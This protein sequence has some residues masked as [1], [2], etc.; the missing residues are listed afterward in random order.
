MGVF[1]RN[2]VNFQ[3]DMENITWITCKI[4]RK[5]EC[6]WWNK[7][8]PGRAHK[9]PDLYCTAQF[10][11]FGGSE[12]KTSTAVIPT[13]SKDGGADMG[14]P[15]EKMVLST[16]PPRTIP[17]RLEEKMAALE[18]SLEL[19]TSAADRKKVSP[20]ISFSPV[21]E[22]SAEEKESEFLEIQTKGEAAVSSTPP[23]TTEGN[24][25]R[26]KIITKEELLSTFSPKTAAQ[27]AS[28]AVTDSV[29]QPTAWG[30][31]VTKQISKCD[32]P[33]VPGPPGPKGDKGDQGPPGQRGL[34]GERGQAGHPGLQGKPGPSL[35][36]R[37]DCTGARN[38]NEKSGER[39]T[40]L[41]GLP[42]PQGM[43]GYSGPPGPPGYPGHEGPQGPPGLPGHEGQQ[44][45][46]GLPGAPGQPGPPGSTGLPG[47]PGPPGAEGPPGIIGP[48][49]HPG[50]PGHVGP[51]GPPGYPGQ[52]GSPGA[53][54][55]PGK[56]GLKGEKGETGPQGPT[57]NPGQ[58]G[59][60]GPQGLP[61]PMGP[62][63]LPG[64]NQCN[65]RTSLLGPPGPKGEK[66]DPGEL[67]CHP[68][69]KEAKNGGHLPPFP[70]PSKSWLPFTFQENGNGDTELYG[71]IVPGP[72]G[73]PGNPGL[74]GP[75]GPPGPPG[76]LYL[77]KMH[78]VRARPHCKQPNH[79]PPLGSDAELLLKDSSDGNQYGLQRSTWLFRSKELM[80]KASSSVP[81]GSLVYI[82]EGSE[83]F[84]RTPKGWSRLLLEDPEPLFMGDDPLVLKKK[85]QE[86]SATTQNIPTSNSQKLRSIYLVALN[87]PLTGHMNGIRGADLQC[88]QQSK[89]KNLNGTFRAFLSSSTQNLVSIVKR[90]DRGLPIVNL[91]G[92]V[93]AKSWNSLFSGD[94]ASYFNSRRF[95]IYTF[96]GQN[97]ITD[98][99]WSHKAVWHGIKQWG[100][101]SPNQDCQDWRTASRQSEG[102]AS[103]LARGKFLTEEKHSCSDSLIVLCV[104]NTSSSFIS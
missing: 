18:K 91:K 1:H 35:P 7:P 42:G 60:R 80:F 29:Q 20:S 64:E 13:S 97:V 74:P 75:P 41:E 100:G 43:P 2:M 69:Y 16:L 54:G 39:I 30:Y 101:R 88:Y 31:S 23:V 81:E 102:L 62:P 83:A 70:G 5:N 27:E 22:G 19:A 12:K 86:G 32:C 96:N 33:A 56:D 59:E 34:P 63:G 79:D 65:T 89:E 67:D 26:A 53:E 94:G 49:G 37:P 47:T 72:P 46:P 38:G 93:L 28:K 24:H 51:P 52:E 44:G 98:P 11:F 95:P 61:G 99:I 10:W 57:G 55:L 85:N 103:S 76:V 92:Q 71:A 50:L 4:A 66:G 84:F 3:W 40:T 8:L 9:R 68:C 15:S 104:E 25:Q 14:Q 6:S 48:E 21:F 45:A 36:V 17:D 90:T 77:S 58:M 82:S 73:P 87:I 78:P